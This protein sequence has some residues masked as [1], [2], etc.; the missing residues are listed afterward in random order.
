[1]VFRF[2][3]TKEIISNLRKNSY[4][5]NLHKDNA[6]QTVTTNLNRVTGS[7]ERF[8]TQSEEGYGVFDN[9]SSSNA[10]KDVIKGL[11]LS[12]LQASLTGTVSSAF[13]LY[14]KAVMLDFS[15][16]KEPTFKAASNSLGG[17]YSVLINSFAERE[18]IGL[19]YDLLQISGMQS[20]VLGYTI[21][22]SV[23]L[24]ASKNLGKTFA[25]RTLTGRLYAIATASLA[26][27]GLMSAVRGAIRGMLLRTGVRVAAGSVI[28][29]IGNAAMAVLSVLI[30]SFL[31]ALAINKMTT[32]KKQS[33][34]VQ[35]YANNK[36]FLDL[37]NPNKIIPFY[38][39][40]LS[41]LME[42]NSLDFSRLIGP[43]ENSFSSS[44]YESS[45]L[46]LKNLGIT[47]EDI[48]Q[49]GTRLSKQTPVDISQLDLLTSTTL[50]Y[51]LLLTGG[52][53][54]SMSSI[55]TSII[56]ATP[57]S[58]QD[59]NLAVS[60]F[61][62][63]FVRV[64]GEGKPQGAHLNLVNALAEF[65]TSY[66]ALEKLSDSAPLQI[67]KIN[68]FMSD[69]G[70]I[71]GRFDVSATKDIIKTV[72]NLMF[73][74]A[75]SADAASRAVFLSSGMSFEE[76]ING[77]TYDAG[78]FTKFLDGIAQFMGLTFNEIPTGEIVGDSN[79]SNQLRNLAYNL[80][81]TSRETQLINHALQRRAMGHDI[82]SIMKEYDESS[83]DPS[84]LVSNLNKFVSFLDNES[85]LN[86]L[87]ALTE[88][89]N[90]L[91]EATNAYAGE[92]IRMQSAVQQLTFSNF[93][94]YSE[95][96]VNTAKVLL[97]S[98]PKVV[99]DVDTNSPF[100][101][102][103]SSSASNV[104]DSH[105]SRLSRELDVH[106]E[107]MGNSVEVQTALRSNFSE[108]LHFTLNLIDR[109]E[110]R[111]SY[112]TLFNHSNTPGRDYEDVRVS[113]MTLQE[114]LEFSLAR[115]E[116]S[117]FEW[118]KR[119]N[120]GVGSTPMGRYQFIGTTVQDV[121]SR[122]GFDGSL[123]FNKETQDRMFIWYAKDRLSGGA[124]AEAKREILLGV[125]R[126]LD[127]DYIST[128]DIDRIIRE[129]E[130][131]SLDDDDDLSSTSPTGF[132]NRAKSMTIKIPIV[133]ANPRLFARD[134]AELMRNN[135]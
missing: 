93:K 97:D 62:D 28:P 112:D 72:D 117:Y 81:L 121:M 91:L 69:N 77:V 110:G 116:D 14:K 54:N 111:G 106:M 130:Q 12:I 135:V 80:G 76:A 64:V 41:L 55:M 74:G 47:S 129:I 36:A 115:G 96:V 44:V 39:Q 118:V 49:L 127:K 8:V 10:K 134:F 33:E 71:N 60:A 21:P 59:V 51:S 88:S 94:K 103:S 48:A 43:G 79:Y 98:I 66:G 78:T 120:A 87:G 15:Y 99:G 125:W 90:K 75:I 107:S 27:L 29:G 123:I 16:V 37:I 11:P 109:T 122:G 13:L 102:S 18:R 128:D 126:G 114:V 38:K 23:A 4:S 108:S 53:L 40:N 65:S 20:L 50:D 35:E 104:Y 73:R 34:A 24:L 6:R 84:S 30:E 119:R 19:Q 89:N 56:K 63:F 70:S 105:A 45:R 5:Q 131:F 133:T 124:S 67:S 1:M 92:I 52:D 58:S 32:D 57:F 68:Q 86:V 46:N 31:L 7:L 85:S 113:N 101:A 61:E 83:K 3:E 100:T 17:Y 42:F 2:N 132:D 9:S 25:S 82:S 22:T 95:F 26:R